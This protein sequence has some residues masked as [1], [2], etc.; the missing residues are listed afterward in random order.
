MLLDMLQSSSPYLVG[1]ILLAVLAFAGSLVPG[2]AAILVAGAALADPWGVAVV[3][4]AGCAG[5][6]LYATGG[7]LVGRRY[8]SRLRGGGAGRRIGERRWSRAERL[9]TATGAGSGPALAAAFFLPVV[10]WLTPIA[11]GARSVPYTRLVRWALAGGAAWVT[12]YLSLGALAGD[13]LRQNRHLLVP[14]LVCVAVVVAALLVINHRARPSR[15]GTGDAGD[16]SDVND[17]NGATGS[18][19]ATGRILG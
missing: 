8:G 2:V 18:G 12:V 5:C 3:A 7:W 11:A 16:T 14:I 4:L 13:F 15:E 19:D 17:T 6:V 9:A 1:S 10:G